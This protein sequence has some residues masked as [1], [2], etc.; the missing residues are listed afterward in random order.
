[1]ILTVAWK[2]AEAFV[3]L[4]GIDIHSALF[5]YENSF[6]NILWMHSNLMISRT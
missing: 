1:M 5:E 6:M 2:E 3:N 4:N